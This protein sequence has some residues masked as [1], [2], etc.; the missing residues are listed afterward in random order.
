MDGQSFN[1]NEINNGAGNDF[2]PYGPYTEGTTENGSGRTFSESNN[3]YYQDNT[4]SR[5]VYQNYTDKSETIPPYQDSFQQPQPQKGETNALAIVG[6]VMG[7]IS[8]VFSCCYGSGILFGIAGLICSI[9]ANKQNK[10]GA[11]TAGLVTSIIGIVISVLV[12]IV[13]IIAI[14]Y[15]FTTEMMY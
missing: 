15:G 6:M 3:S 10:T 4:G 12:L 2:N 1:N 11:G 14:A 9:I 8:I 5:S 13:V 7:I